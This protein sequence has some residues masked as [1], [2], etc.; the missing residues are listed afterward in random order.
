MKMWHT[1]TTAEQ[2]FKF[3]MFSWLEVMHDVGEEKDKSFDLC[4]LAMI[5]RGQLLFDYHLGWGHLWSKVSA[6]NLPTNTLVP[7]SA[8][9]KKGAAAFCANFQRRPEK[10]ISWLSWRG[11]KDILA[12]LDSWGFDR[13]QWPH[14]RW[15]A[16]NTRSFHLQ[17]RSSFPWLVGLMYLLN[18][19]RT[20]SSAVMR[21][22]SWG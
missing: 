15:A 4:S 17:L 18:I 3:Y 16:S 2:P 14:K 20:R 22:T 9:E 6:S 1:Q 19:L 7:A 8:P 21:R 13:C 5:W 10:V 11:Q 12:M